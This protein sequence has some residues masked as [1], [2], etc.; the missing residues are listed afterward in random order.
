MVKEEMYVAVP[1]ECYREPRSGKGWWLL[2]G[3]A[4]GVL[5]C[6]VGMIVIN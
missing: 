3:L 5:L 6:L 4:A 2:V 1:V